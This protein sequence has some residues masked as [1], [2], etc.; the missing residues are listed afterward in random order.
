MKVQEQA[1]T[2]GGRGTALAACFRLG[3]DPFN[4]GAT[5]NFLAD[6]TGQQEKLWTSRYV[7]ALGFDNHAP[8]LRNFKCIGGWEV[9]P[10]H[11]QRPQLSCVGY[12]E[13][14]WASGGST[15]MQ[16]K[17]AGRLE[18]HSESSWPSTDLHPSRLVSVQLC[19]VLSA[20]EIKT[21]WG[22]RPPVWVA[23]QGLSQVHTRETEVTEHFSP[24]CVLGRSLDVS[25]EPKNEESQLCKTE[26]AISCTPILR[27]SL[28]CHSFVLPNN[29][30]RHFTGC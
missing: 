13:K 1:S 29:D 12:K 21:E 24:W 3:A 6:R 30:K 18:E 9:K 8:T 28:D 7:S 19:G 11:G 27:L 25:V 5:R 20:T 23:S 17:G 15:H 14:P 22:H 2:R 16:S 4:T 26:Q 10:R